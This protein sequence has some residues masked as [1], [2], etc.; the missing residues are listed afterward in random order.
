MSSGL[1]SSV[2]LRTL[3]SPLMAYHLRLHIEGCPSR[4][5]APFM[6]QRI[7]QEGESKFHVGLKHE[8]SLPLT[9]HTDPWAKENILRL[10]FWKEPCQEI[11]AHVRIDWY[12]SAGKSL[13][14]Y[15]PS[16]PIYLFVI[17]WT[18]FLYQQSKGDDKK[19]MSIKVYERLILKLYTRQSDVAVRNVPG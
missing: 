2:A 3:N 4:F 10:T 9:F 13:L 14:R 5:F 11:S 7:G 16:I 12:G 8:A 15:G 6:Q 19:K 17:H 1:C 18:I